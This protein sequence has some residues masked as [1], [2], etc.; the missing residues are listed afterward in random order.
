ML[1]LLS[2]Q[3]PLPGEGRLDSWPGRRQWDPPNNWQCHCTLFH[4]DLL[5]PELLRWV[6]PPEASQKQQGLKLDHYKQGY[7]TMNVPS[8]TH[9]DPNL[10]FAGAEQVLQRV[11]DY[12]AR[13]DNCDH[14]ICPPVGH[15]PET[16][17]GLIPVGPRA[18]ANGKASQSGYKCLDLALS[19][20]ACVPVARRMVRN[21]YRGF[22]NI[23]DVFK[24]TPS[25]TLR[26]GASLISTG[27]GCLSNAN[28]K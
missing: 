25:L 2:S 27:K 14:L 19:G 24:M 10:H 3:R 26:P 12:K 16:C 9:T 21:S 20:A 18:N 15:R 8:Q 5:L 17:P 11:S 4:T 7:K 1:G 6:P 13:R 23:Q 22:K 28:R